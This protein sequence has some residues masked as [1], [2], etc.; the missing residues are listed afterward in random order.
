MVATADSDQPKT[1]T[2]HSSAWLLFGRRRRKKNKE[3]DHY[4]SETL[5]YVC[6][7]LSLFCFFFSLVTTSSVFLFTFIC[8]FFHISFSLLL[9][10]L[11]LL[12]CCYCFHLLR[13]TY[14][15]CE[16]K[17]HCLFWAKLFANGKET[18]SK[19]ERRKKNQCS[20]NESAGNNNGN[21]CEYKK[22]KQQ[23]I[24]CHRAPWKFLICTANMHDDYHANDNNQIMLSYPHSPTPLYS[25]TYFSGSHFCSFVLYGFSLI[26]IALQR[27]FINTIVLN[28][29]II[30]VY[31]FRVCMNILCD[32]V[33]IQINDNNQ[34]GVWRRRR[35]K[36]STRIWTKEW[37]RFPCVHRINGK[38]ILSHSIF[39]VCARA[40]LFFSRFCRLLY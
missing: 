34:A 12:L 11:I 29:M 24:S 5:L 6:T 38:S 30:V 3:H 7:F 14:V 31:E 37:D 40:K 36:S 21:V 8:S 1:F 32:Y 18:S 28:L 39:Y 22:S 19:W 20:T 33:L 2:Q 23:L 16:K 13:Y 35:K 17:K 26:Y 27:C 10:L 4:I 15:A 9:R 25:V